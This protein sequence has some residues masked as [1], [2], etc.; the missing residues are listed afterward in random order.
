VDLVTGGGELADH[1]ERERHPTA[2]H[3]DL[4]RSP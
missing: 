2:G 3:E 1:A 4:H